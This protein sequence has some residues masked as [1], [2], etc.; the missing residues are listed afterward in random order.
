MPRIY[1]P[2]ELAP[3]VAPSKSVLFDYTNQAWVVDGR[4]VRCGHPASMACRC[5][6]LIHE[7]EIVRPDAEVN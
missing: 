2:I 3:R 1:Q 7:G 6:G 4:Y 5:F